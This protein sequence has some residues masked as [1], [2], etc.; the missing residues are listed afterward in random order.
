MKKVRLGLYLLALVVVIFFVIYTL[1]KKKRPTITANTIFIKNPQETIQYYK[2]VGMSL[3]KKSKEAPEEWKGKKNRVLSAVQILT[4]DVID[5]NVICLKNWIY[6][7][8]ELDI[9][10]LI[11]RYIDESL[12][13][14]RMDYNLP[15]LSIT[16]LDANNISG[17]SLFHRGNAT[18]MIALDFD[19][20]LER[21]QISKKITEIGNSMI[22]NDEIYNDL[23]KGDGTIS[24]V[25]ANNNVLDKLNIDVP[26]E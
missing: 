17:G 19:S 24:L 11:I 4:N 9:K 5:P 12:R 6:H 16:L 1:Q 22:F 25:D 14:K 13:V 18:W 15:V 3:N 23:I 21:N 26:K 2:E 10:Y 8:T 7:D 20:N